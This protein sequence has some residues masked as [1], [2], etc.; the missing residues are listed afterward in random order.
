MTQDM[1]SRVYQVCQ[2]MDFR[3]HM[4]NG[5]IWYDAVFLAF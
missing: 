5:M 2:A 3:N 1:I 4:L